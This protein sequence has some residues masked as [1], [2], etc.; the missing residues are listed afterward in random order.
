MIITL[1]GVI[2]IV[3]LMTF[4]IFQGHR[5]Q[6]YKLQILCLGFLSSE[7]WTMYGHYV[8]WNDYAQY[9]L[10]DSGVYPV[11]IINMLFVSQVSLHVK[12]FNIWVYLCTINVMNVKL[13]MMVL[14]IELY[15]FIVSHYS[16][17]WPYFKVTAISNS[18]Y[19]EF[20]I[21]ILLS[22]NFVG[23][24]VGASFPLQS[25]RFSPVLFPM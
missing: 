20:C 18:F 7:V 10:C 13:C 2:A 3:G 25:A 21:H 5:C 12:N 14:L 15:M 19:W 8:H 23:L 1:L 24:I 11:V 17:P 6:K 22:S 9:D 16:P 4:T